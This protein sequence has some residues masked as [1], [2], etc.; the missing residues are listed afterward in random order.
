MRARAEVPGRCPPGG[1]LDP[2]V[3]HRKLETAIDRLLLTAPCVKVILCTT[4]RS[5]NSPEEANTCLRERNLGLFRFAARC[6]NSS[7]GFVINNFV[8]K[9][10]LLAAIL[11]SASMLIPV[12]AVAQDAQLSAGMSASTGKPA[13][14]FGSA[15]AM[16]IGGSRPAKPA[17]G[18]PKLAPRPPQPPQPPQGV[19]PYSRTR[20]SSNKMPRRNAAIGAS[21]PAATGNFTWLS[22]AGFL[23]PRTNSGIEGGAASLINGK[24]YVSHGFRGS[25]GLFLSIYDLASDAWT[26]GGASAPDASVVRSEMGGGTALG[27]HYAIGGRTAPSAANEEFDPATNAWKTKTPMTTARGGLGVASWNN[28]IFA[29]GGRTG[30]TYGTGAILNGNEVYDSATDTWG[31]LAPL[32]TPVSDNYSTA[33]FN[34]KIYVIGGTTGG[35]S[36]LTNL[37]QIYDIASDTWSLGAPMPTPRG[38]AMAGVIAGEIAVFGGVD[39]ATA[40][41]A[42]TEIYDP[43][44]NSWFAGPDLL[45]AASEL[46]QGVTYDGKQIFSIGRG[47]FGVSGQMVQQLVVPILGASPVSVPF[48]GVIINNSS[49][50]MD[51]TLTNAGSAAMTFSNFSVGG[52]NNGDF[53][54]TNNCP[55]SPA[56]LAPSGACVV[57]V[58]FKP[59]GIGTRNGTLTVNSDSAGNPF[60]VPLSGSGTDFSVAAATGSSCPAGGNCS[61][62][63]AVTAGQT[64]T[65]NLMLTPAGGF[66]GTVALSCSGAPSLANCTA[67]PPVTPDGISASPFTVTVS[68]T[69][70]SM[71]VHRT[72]P[73]RTWPWG[74]RLKLPL[75]LALALIS[76]L[77]LR[78]LAVAVGRPRPAVVLVMALASLA[79]VWIGGCDEASKQMIPGTPPGT[80]P[81]VI[82]GTSGGVT[83]TI[84]LTLTV[85]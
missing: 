25:D 32:P 58:T 2:I 52:T 40:D 37:V 15:G 82:T 46:A 65:Y 6:R 12:R 34:G 71:M 22:K 41:L 77:M 51:V 68:T 8:T 18:V 14:N 73:P 83:H 48:G 16:S 63:A 17:L 61:M 53:A 21:I 44:S 67:P 42:V 85:N 60:S 81:L 30:A 70:P 56:T 23:D 78:K 74:A 20:T 72:D 50:G 43:A 35:N 84:N 9:I 1:L 45:T 47:I 19:S 79:A 57:N 49:A 10:F 38:A 39:A 31:T 4:P 75:L 13:G 76:I 27:K 69:A 5:R 11:F 55:A 29:I 26:H 80:V 59:T 7:G 28:K 64:A 62:S 36:G 54:Q 24:I 66:N 33:T 3:P